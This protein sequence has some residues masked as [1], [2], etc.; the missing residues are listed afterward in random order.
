MARGPVSGQVVEAS[1]G[2]SSANDPA[3]AQGQALGPE[4][5][6]GDVD[7][8]RELE[9]E[10]SGPVPA[11][12]SVS[13]VLGGHDDS[14]D[15]ELKEASVNV[16]MDAIESGD[17]NLL[18]ET[19]SDDG[20]TLLHLAAGSGLVDS[21]Q[22]LMKAGGKKLLF[23]TNKYGL[24]ALQY[25]S[26]RDRVE[27]MWLLIEAGGKKLLRMTDCDG[28][29]ALYFAAG[30]G[31]VESMLQLIEV[32]GMELVLLKKY[33][34]TVLHT[35]AD[36]GHEAAAWMLIQA[37]G[38]KLLFKTNCNG[39]SALHQAA[40]GGHVESMLQLIEAGGTRG[41]RSDAHQGRRKRAAF[42]N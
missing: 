11:G 41:R 1:R 3:N 4:Y 25:A 38:Q 30:V 27:A 17:Q 24:S 13:R 42:Q 28:Q 7:K 6:S 32:G 21:V 39:F 20:A 2:G 31:C 16:V 14:G 10:Q 9:A 35:A 34:Q 15:A 37:G 8:S 19:F 12:G 40:Y 36:N 23:A 26:F 33:G 5:N 18:L 29:S 22:Q